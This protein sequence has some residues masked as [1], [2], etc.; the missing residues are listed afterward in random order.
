MPQI[1]LEGACVIAAVLLAEGESNSGT[2]M[3]P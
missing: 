1:A 2:T 3:H